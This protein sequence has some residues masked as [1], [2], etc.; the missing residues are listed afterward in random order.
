MF[1]QDPPDIGTGQNDPG[2][3]DPG[4]G[5]TLTCAGSLD[6]SFSIGSGVR[7]AQ[8]YA[9]EAEL[10]HL[11]LE[12][13]GN[14]LIYGSFWLAQG[15]ARRGLARLRP[16]GTLDPDFA[17]ELHGTVVRAVARQPN[18]CLIVAG[19]FT[20]V[21]RT[22]R[23]QIARLEPD[24]SLDWGFQPESDVDFG[25]IRALAVQSDGKII[26]AGSGMATWQAT[27][28]VVLRLEPH[29]ALDKDF[30]LTDGF[31]G[32]VR[33][34][35]A[36]PDGKILLGGSSSVFTQ[37][38]PTL[39][40]RLNADG[41]PDTSFACPLQPNGG[42]SAFALQPDGRILV[43]GVLQPAPGEPGLGL[44]RLKPD[45]AFDPTFRSE[46]RLCS[47]CD[48]RTL[49][50]DPQGRILIGGRFDRLNDTSQT[51]VARVNPDGTLDSTFQAS[52]YK[53]P[54][55]GEGEF[56]SGMALQP[57]G[58]LL[59]AGFLTRING[60]EVRSAARL[61]TTCCDCPSLISLT[62]PS[63]W[64]DERRA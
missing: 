63:Y 52:M 54:E 14:V 21:G 41:T 51:L 28:L 22:W 24:G 44:V 48:V 2:A 34:V 23:P 3:D 35:A 12:P 10:E 53:Y 8:G 47:D 64:V 7:T 57:D 1:A 6:T 5:A 18:G 13:N 29:G 59:I 31:A 32:Q 45:G 17:P 55:T 40:V 4:S 25:E 27:N 39:L 58:R 19:D 60:H 15:E 37:G 9:N 30:V 38:L 16:N 11:L 50:L 56:V 36:Q 33:A 49:V 46:V 62:A 26:V 61:F 20:A 42:V 43:G